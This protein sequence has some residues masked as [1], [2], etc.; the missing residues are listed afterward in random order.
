MQKKIYKYIYIY[1]CGDQSLKGKINGRT[2]RAVLGWDGVPRSR[3][4]GGGGGGCAGF[5]RKLTDT[6]FLFFL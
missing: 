2:P 3:P 6:G 4:S 5:K 1:I